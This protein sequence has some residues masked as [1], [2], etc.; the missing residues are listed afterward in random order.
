[1]R[2]SDIPRN[3]TTRTLRQFGVLCV[4]VFGGF[5]AWRWMSS[6][7]SLRVFVM[8]GVATV[9]GLL[10]LIAPSLL[11]PIFVGWMVLAFPMGW[12]VSRVALILLFGVF[13]TPFALFF[14]V[15]GRD[16][17]RLRRRSNETTYWRA[18]PSAPDL[19]SYFRQS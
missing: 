18:K 4:L 2:W 5:A 19:S 6:G 10:A 9:A 16:L 11:R 12:L 8:G 17:L 1:M 14:R 3:P 13:I 7:A 15:T